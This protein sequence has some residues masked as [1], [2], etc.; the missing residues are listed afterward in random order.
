MSRDDD[1]RPQTSLL[2]AIPVDIPYRPKFEIQIRYCQ[3][4]GEKYTPVYFGQAGCNDDYSDSWRED[5]TRCYR[6]G[7]RY[8]QDGCSEEKSAA[9]IAQEAQSDKAKGHGTPPD[10]DDHG[11]HE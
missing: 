10:D 9:R 6:S 5:W 4:C 2:D 1:R 8:T 7:L 3:D 11:G